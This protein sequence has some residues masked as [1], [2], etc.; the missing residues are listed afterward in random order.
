MRATRGRALLHRTQGQES[1][2]EGSDD[3]AVGLGRE[4]FGPLDGGVAPS[5]LHVVDDLGDREVPNHVSPQ[6]RQGVVQ[7]R[8]CRRL[9]NREIQGTLGGRATIIG[10]CAISAMVTFTCAGIRIQA[11]ADMASCT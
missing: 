5:F 10:L 8:H 6:A 4:V 9:E 7:P 1:L 3:G 11:N 2:R